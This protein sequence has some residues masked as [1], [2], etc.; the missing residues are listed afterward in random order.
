MVTKLRYANT[1]IYLLR[2]DKGNVLVDTDYAGTLMKFGS[3]PANIDNYAKASSIPTIT[4]S[5][6]GE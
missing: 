6:K 4:Q 5:V 2:G 3:K 1:N